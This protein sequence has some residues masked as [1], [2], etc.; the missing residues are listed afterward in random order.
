MRLCD[1]LLELKQWA[2]PDERGRMDFRN[3]GKALKMLRVQRLKKQ[4][5]IAEAAGITPAMLSAYETGK[6]RPSLDTAERVL[7][8]LDCDILDLTRVLKTIDLEDQERERKKLAEEGGATNSDGAQLLGEV[9]EEQLAQADLGPEE[10]DLLVT[11]LPGFL[12]LIR[13]LKAL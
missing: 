3:I 8:A 4:R 13:Y 10:R 7:G 2:L 12:K 6:H 5:E 9:M 11:L 1:N